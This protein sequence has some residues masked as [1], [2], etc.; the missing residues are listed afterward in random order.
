MSSH[1]R[2]VVQDITN[3]STLDEVVKKD[4]FTGSLSSLLDP[5]V[6]PAQ[7]A[8]GTSRGDVPGLD[9]QVLG[10]DV[11]L[12]PNRALESDS[13]DDVMLV[14]F[15]DR[16]IIHHAAHPPSPSPDMSNTLDDSLLARF[17]DQTLVDRA[18]C[19]PT[20][21]PNMCN[22]RDNDMLVR[23]VDQ[24]LEDD[25]MLVNCTTQ[26][27]VMLA[28]FVDQTLAALAALPPNP[29]ANV[30]TTQ[31]DA[32]LVNFVDETLAQH[33]SPPPSLQDG[34]GNSLDGAMLAEHADQCTT[35]ASDHEDSYMSEADDIDR[36]LLEDDDVFWH[37]E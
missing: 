22:T 23:F 13:E 29:S 28:D 35:G 27:D 21:S 26:D 5:Q 7:S 9:E 36:W 30:T 20:P 17:V 31:D 1:R 16:T 14:H 32:M 2:G 33:I 19:P 18:P 10:S 8:P 15:V 11:T 34:L 6:Q 12:S 25:A 4:L 3:S 24:T 37:P